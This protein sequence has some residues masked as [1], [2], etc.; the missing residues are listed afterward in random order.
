M[1]SNDESLN[2]SNARFL[3]KYRISSSRFPNHDYNGGMYFIT[4]CT[5]NR[6]HFFGEI[7]DGKMHPSRIGIYLDEQINKTPQIRKD[8]NLEI[9]LYVI[10][11]N[12][13]HLIICISENPYNNLFCHLKSSG[14]TTTKHSCFK[15]QR[16]NL[17]SVIRGLKSIITHFAKE[18]NIVFSW[19]PRYHDHIIRNDGECNR[20]ADYIENNVINWTND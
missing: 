11:P 14:T 5:S 3:N 8:M 20:I 17:A 9:P 7:Y 4:I 16:K 10:M 19:Q 15:P 2:G 6:I 1:N 12:H 18:N 13:V